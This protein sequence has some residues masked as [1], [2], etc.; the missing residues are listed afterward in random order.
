MTKDSNAVDDALWGEVRAHFDESE[1]LELAVAIGLF[2]Y[3][4][5]VNNTLQ[6]E[7]TK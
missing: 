3:F 4:N 2:N 7:P 5:M 1:C 6:M